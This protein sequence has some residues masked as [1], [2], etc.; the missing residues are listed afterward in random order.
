MDP[1]QVRIYQIFLSKYC[2]AHTLEVSKPLWGK[3]TDQSYSSAELVC[4]PAG[5][6]LV[7]TCTLTHFWGS[8]D[9]TN[10]E[11]I[12]INQSFD[13]SLFMCNQLAANL[14]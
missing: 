6:Y 3:R 8:S 14:V 12:L 7:L 4:V 5:R 11:F 10:W 2:P 1:H 9:F 13:F